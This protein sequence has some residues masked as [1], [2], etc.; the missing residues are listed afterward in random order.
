MRK[1]PHCKYI[2]YSHITL[3]YE[4][5]KL[6]RT[7]YA[8]GV[9]PIIVGGYVRDALLGISNRKDIDIEIYGLDSYESLQKLLKPFGKVNLVGKSF[10]VCKLRIGSLECDFSLPR[11]ENKVASGHKG[12]EI[13]ID[14]Q[15]SFFE[16]SKRRDFTINALGYDPIKKELIDCHGGIQDLQNKTLKAVDK[17]TFKEDP[18]RVLRTVVFAARFGFQLDPSLFHTCK[19]MIAEGML[20]ELPKER[21]F[22]ELKKLFQ[23]AKRPSIAFEL[24]DVMQERYYFTEFFQLPKGLQK[25]TL[26]SIDRL[27]SKN[28]HELSLYFALL[29]RKVRDKNSFLL[30][31]TTNKKL[32]KEIFTL[33]ECLEKSC[34]LLQ[35]ESSAFEVK[36]LATTCNI[37]KSLLLLR[38]LYPKMEPFFSRLENLAKKLDVFQQPPSPLITGKELIHAGLSPSKEFKE[39]L[40]ELYMQQLAGNPISKEKLKEYL[41]SQGYLN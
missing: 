22:E 36:L 26:A 40:H 28:I 15:L 9:K 32:I 3:P 38:A 16:A 8:K 23:R 4:L 37:E 30:R 24:L 20:Q 33:L 17:N 31:F 34:I 19:T 41:Q 14:P 10:G 29:I 6:L 21:I 7:L 5:D 11:R 25:H 35:K 2:P 39:I 12:F 18:L 13:I 27:A 1:T